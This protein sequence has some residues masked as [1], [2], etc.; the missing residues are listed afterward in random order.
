[1]LLMTAVVPGSAQLAGGNRKI[2]RVGVRAWLVLVALGIAYV[3]LFLAARGAAVG[4][5][6]TGWVLWTLSWVV[7]AAGIGWALLMV[8]AWWA[9]SPRDMGRIRGTVFSVVAGV[10]AVTLGWGTIAV[11]SAMRSGGTALS[12][13]LGGGGDA[14]QKE[15]RY[16]F[17]V[18]GGDA[19]SDREGMRADSITV[20]SVDAVTGRTVLFGLPRNLEQVPF[21]ESSPLSTLYPKG[22]DCP[23]HSCLLNAVYLLGVQHKDLY[24]GV[25]YPGVQATKEAVEAILGLDINYFVLMDMGG[26]V[27]LIDAVGGIN[28]DVN[29]RVPIAGGAGGYIEVGPN[30]HLDG[31]KALW[32][33]RSRTGTT[34]YDRMA[35]QK[36]VISAMINQLDPLT[37]A[38][39]F[40]QIAS[41]SQQIVITDVPASSVNDLVELAMK[42][43]ALP[44]GS[45]SFTP[46]AIA[47]GT[48]NYPK[49]R[50]TVKDTIAQAE[51]L[52]GEPAAPATAAETS[53]PVTPAAPA[54][55]T[56]KSTAKTTQPTATSTATADVGG[57]SDLTAVCTAH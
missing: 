56:K 31:T 52:D 25:K 27:D 51:Q 21:P 3:V 41:A 16:N 18:I 4:L 17:L 33:S 19:G 28:L 37:V 54:T 14:K 40:S 30:Q 57:V 6:A 22:Y 43:K 39:K 44:V 23:D 5:L 32:F 7:L 10:L 36:C 35:R 20:A 13:V 38:T 9:A 50:Q 49:I 34:D 26:F 8:N 2:G 1:M 12:S 45:V 55:S 46:P 48:P 42:A 15:G 47:P 53:A 24:P 11:A 29:E